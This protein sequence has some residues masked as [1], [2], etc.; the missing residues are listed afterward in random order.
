MAFK[1]KKSP[2]TSIEVEEECVDVD[3]GP[4]KGKK[5]RGKSAYKFN[6]GDKSFSNFNKKQNKAR[7]AARKRGAYSASWMK[8]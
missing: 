3:L 7:R 2:L 5:C 1:L 8:K 6:R 4:G